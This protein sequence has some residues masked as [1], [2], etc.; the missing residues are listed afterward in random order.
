MH[1]YFGKLVYIVCVVEFQYRGLPH[2]HIVLKVLPELPFMFIDATVMVRILNDP[3]LT[4]V[5]S[6]ILKYNM[7]SKDHLKKLKNHCNKKRKCIFGF[8]FNLATTT[9]LDS[10]GCVIYR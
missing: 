5:C 1:M 10:N 8:P 6:K 2:A 4:D 7:H 3:E 9:S